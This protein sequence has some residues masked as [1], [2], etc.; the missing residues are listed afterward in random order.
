[1]KTILTSLLLP[2]L[3][4]SAGQAAT[5]QFNLQ[6][7]GGTGL[8]ATNEPNGV[9]AAAA[10][11]SGG[12]I[13]GGITFDDVSLI[14]S[15]KVGWGAT[16][17]FTNLTGPAAAGHIHGPTGAAPP[18]SFAQSVG[19]KYPLDSV[20]GWNPSASAGGFNGNVTILPADVAGLMQGRFY[21]NVHTTL[22]GGGEIR[23]SLIPVPEPSVSLMAA[24]ASLGLLTLRRRR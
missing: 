20:A 9:S 15:I 10:A 22:N 18:A 19:V 16:N 7:L 5:I 11:G 14:M 3:L 21:V 1:M 12:E 24:S 23:G 13:L 4:A 2:L 8:L 17:G 6:G